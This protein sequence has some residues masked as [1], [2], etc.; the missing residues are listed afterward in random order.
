MSP[1]RQSAIEEITTRMSDSDIEA[2]SQ[3]PG[4]EAGSR[5]LSFMVQKL[6]AWGSTNLAQ[7][8]R[9]LMS[10]DQLYVI[11]PDLLGLLT[12]HLE[13]LSI[14]FQNFELDLVD[15]DL[16]SELED[17][18]FSE[19]FRNF[20]LSL[21][22]T[23]GYVAKLIRSSFEEGPPDVEMNFKQFFE[24]ALLRAATEAVDGKGLLYAD[25]TELPEVLLG[26]TEV[27]EQYK[28]ELTKIFRKSVLG[29]AAVQASKMQGVTM[30]QEDLV[31]LYDVLDRDPSADADSLKDQAVQFSL[32]FVKSKIGGSQEVSVNRSLR[33][34]FDT[35]AFDGQSQI[36]SAK[37]KTA[38]AVFLGKGSFPK[39]TLSIPEIFAVSGAIL[40]AKISLGSSRLKKSSWITGPAV[41]R[42]SDA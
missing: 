39:L 12:H 2:M 24:G 38:S 35:I 1:L 40:A 11:L 8:V 21:S 14:Q 28:A 16:L 36:C 15:V 13:K 25:S 31:R 20:E 41:S 22:K 19:K 26:Y 32:T 23:N 34:L 10:R 17:E 9:E 4:G 3:D 37:V 27:F 33:P 5:V 18:Q 6:S 30:Q 29:I 7:E 42:F